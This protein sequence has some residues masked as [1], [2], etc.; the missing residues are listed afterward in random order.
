MKKLGIIV[1]E[2]N[3]NLLSFLF[4]ESGW[5]D[6]R[7]KD[8]TGYNFFALGISKIDHGAAIYAV[9]LDVWRDMGKAELKLYSKDKQLIKDMEKKHFASGEQ[10]LELLEKINKTNLVKLSNKQIL[11]YFNKIYK[12]DTALCAYGFSFVCIDYVN[13]FL[14]NKLNAIL[15]KKAK[16]RR[17]SDYFSSLTVILD[18]TFGAKEKRDILKLALK[19]K[20]KNVTREKRD[21][22]IEKH[23]KKYRWITY[24][25]SGPSLSKKFFEEE[26]ADLIQ[27]GKLKQKL[28]EMEEQKKKAEKKIKKAVK[29]LGLDAQEKYLFDLA[30]KIIFLK[31]YRKEVLVLSYFLLGEL[32]KEVSRRT[33]I[34][35]NELRTM[36][37]EEVNLLL[38]K[39]KHPSVK[40][41]RARKNHVLCVSTDQ[42]KTVFSGQK[43]KDYFK[44]SVTQKRVTKIIK[45]LNGQ[46]ASPGLVK[47][48]VKIVNEAEDMEKM[49]EG[50]VLIS[51]QTQPEL[52]PA[53]KIAAAIVTDQGGMTC[54]AAIV[55][56]E[57]NVPCVIGT[58][59]AT[60]V[61]KDGDLGEVDAH[62]GIV[63][64]VKE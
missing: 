60:N 36:T 21:K 20:S 34:P 44:K 7:L 28:V 29:E 62:H 17:V 49:E 2:Y 11:D 37:P 3:V 46:I 59:V 25:Y 56:R 18:E 6:Q 35:F 57:L 53:M 54:H 23:W 48:K 32:V 30:R 31:G 8:I 26:L 51:H 50:D 47:G 4:N 52:L 13:G 39:G 42:S 64:K 55:S 16:K 33:L 15:K 38:A 1:E 12:I 22:L 5:Y 43:A 61:L 63:R 45:E 27:K 14:T 19:L 9:D 40:E 10:M 58:K 41:L 24:G